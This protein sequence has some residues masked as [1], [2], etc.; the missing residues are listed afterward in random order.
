MNAKILILAAGSSSRL[1]E[2]KQLL[3]FKGETLLNRAI[4]L[5]HSSQIGEIYVVLGSGAKEIAPS[6]KA[7]SVHIV[8]HPDWEKGMGSSLAKGVQAL[9]L[10]S[11]GVFIFL[12]D[13]IKLSNEIIH[14]LKEEATL[15]PDSIICSRYKDNY[16]AP[17][18]FPAI[19][20]DA[21]RK[22]ETAGGAKLL[23]KEHIDEVRF[24]D[25]PGGDVD[26]DYPEDLSLLKE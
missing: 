6:I 18:Y 7:S 21:L 3:T 22:L 23:I 8:Q 1:G 13:Q 12:T 26:I 4:A 9:P 16:G 11:T 2:K 25:F 19:H 10:E 24:I 14:R 5:G 20:F 15:H 17:S